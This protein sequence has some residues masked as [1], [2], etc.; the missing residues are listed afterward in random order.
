VIHSLGGS[1]D[2]RFRLYLIWV[3][4]DI[5]TQHLS[6]MSLSS[7][8]YKLKLQQLL[9]VGLRQGLNIAFSDTKCVVGNGECVV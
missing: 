6:P 1:I 3:L 8:T 2:Q 5:C 4:F 7:S 9:P